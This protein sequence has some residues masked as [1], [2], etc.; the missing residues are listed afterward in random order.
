MHVVAAG[1]AEPALQ[2][3]RRQDLPMH[4]RAGKVREEP[5]EPIHHAIGDLVAT[6]VLRTLAEPVGL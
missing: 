4:D 1:E 6:R 2:V 3:E 5:A